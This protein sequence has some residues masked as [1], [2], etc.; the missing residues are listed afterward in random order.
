M[1][2]PQALKYFAEVARSGSLRHASE[3]FDIVPSA[4]SRQI[5]QLEQ[6]LG[7]ILFERSSRGMALTEAGRVLLEHVDDTD[8]RIGSL[9]RRLDDLS[10]LR[11][12]TIRLAVVEA[13][14]NDFL[15]R[16]LA[17]FAERH[18]GIEFHV[19]VCGTGDIAERLAS[20]A[21]EVALAFNSPSRDDLLLRARIPQPLQLVCAPGHPLLAHRTLSMKQLDGVA[22]AL[23]DRSFGIRRLIEQAEAAARVRLRVAL[24]SDSLQLIKNV[25]AS[26]SLVSFM[27]PMTFTR[28]LASGSL[29][30]ID[31]QGPVFA[32]AS[33]DVLTARGHEI[34]HAARRFLDFLVRAARRPD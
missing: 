16:T 10:E 7:G 19:S 30:A 1:M 29:A 9:R 8:R 6:Q 13:V 18:P 4:I 34:S 17:R 24:E 2:Q 14:T 12:G 15:P 26:T 23:P 21:A 25:V 3:V 5:A 11:R 22:A 20:N 31:L 33:I 28:E 27:P 32:R